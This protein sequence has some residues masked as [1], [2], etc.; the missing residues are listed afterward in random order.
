MFEKVCEKFLFFSFLWK[1]KISA[2]EQW[3]FSCCEKLLNKF[4]LSFSFSSISTSIPHFLFSV[5]HPTIGYGRGKGR[6]Q[7][8]FTLMKSKQKHW[9]NKNCLVGNGENFSSSCFIKFMIKEEEH[10]SQK[11]M[12]NGFIFPTSTIFF[13]QLFLGGTT[14]LELSHLQ[15]KKYVQICNSPLFISSL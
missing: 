15:K 3:I 12:V 11:R 10:S 14:L 2:T 9:V 4:V 13:L 7:K 8:V 1:E 6:Q 5:F